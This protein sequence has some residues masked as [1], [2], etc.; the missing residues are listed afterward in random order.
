MARKLLLVLLVL[1]VIGLG[2]GAAAAQTSS[3]TYTQTVNQATPTVTATSS[4]N[5]STYTQSVTFTATVPTDATGTITFTSD[6]TAIG[7]SPISSGSAAIS[8]AALLAGTHSVVAEYSG[9][10]NYLSANSSPISQVVNKATPGVG[11]VPAVTIASSLNPSVFGQSVTFTATVP[12]DATGTVTFMDG[13][14]TLGTGTVSSGTATFTTSALTG[15][16]HSITAVYGGDSN[17][18]T[19]TSS[20]LSQVVNVQAITV[21]LASSA[22]PGFAQE[23]ITFTATVPAG[24]T[25][26]VTFA[27][28]GTTLGTSPVSSGVA[29][30]T[31][32]TLAVGSHSITAQYSGDTNYGAATSSTL[33]E[34]V[35]K[36]ATISELTIAPALSEPVGTKMTFS[37]LVDTY[38]DTPTGTV[39]FADG[40]NTL[41][42]GTVSS[43]TTTNE[44]LDSNKFTASVWTPE[45]SSNS[46]APTLS[47]P[48]GVVGPNGVA[49]AA[50]QIAYPDTSAGGQGGADYSGLVQT[51]NTTALAGLKGTFSIWLESPSSPATVTLYMTDTASGTAVGTQTCSVG[52]TWTRCSV[53]GTFPAASTGATVS[54]R[55]WGA[56]AETVD[57]WGAQ[58][59]QASAPGPYVQTTSAARK[60]TGGVATFST[61]TLLAGTYK[62][63]AA[64]SGDSNYL[65]ATSA[66]QTLTMTQATP[67]VAL[68]SSANPSTYGQ[69]VTFTAT[70][71]GPTTTPT[72]TVTFKDGTTTLG[73]G[74]LNSSGVATFT[75]AALTGGTHSITAVYGGDSNFGPATST[76][77][78]QTVNV[79]AATIN[80]SSTPNPSVYDQ[81]VTFSLSVAGVT[82]GLTPTGTVTIT[83]ANGTTVGQVTLNSNGDGTI[84]SSSLTAGSHT[85]TITYSGDSNYK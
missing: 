30:Y 9:D 58:L 44:L 51:V 37:A 55:N 61:G 50:I 10:S 72:G 32:S 27:D 40:T 26:T 78:T 49:P 83:D 82:G 29:T 34:T 14:A 45:D 35:N 57:A 76:A 66:N 20:A 53:T 22:N 4:L 41:G 11:G 43:V 68:T 6:G 73:T 70:V 2:A 18:N 77:L 33:T 38:G 63:T 69:S 39:T 1:S 7:T 48:S 54:I 59:E 15:G 42:T 79:A 16:T 8:T 84:T 67:S 56:T 19:A 80:V 47:T 71:T 81:Q 21:N 3:I 62:V 64:Y 17:Y 65:G 52:S 12:S 31:T 23:P 46:Y 13:A 25:G 75:T 5:P 60:G 28:G 24:A 36:T 74:T 85:L